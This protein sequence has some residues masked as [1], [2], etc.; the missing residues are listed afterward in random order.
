MPCLQ[1]GFFAM[2]VCA[3]GGLLYINLGYLGFSNCKHIHSSRF[4]ST[5]S[6]LLTWFSNNTKLHDFLN[7]TIYFCTLICP[8]RT[9][10]LL[11]LHGFLLTGLF[12]QSLKK[13]GKQRTPFCFQDLLHTVQFIK[14]FFLALLMIKDSKQ[15]I[16][17]RVNNKLKPF[18]CRYL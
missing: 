10:S 18:L 16:T 1:K 11:R 9:K 8:F 3:T 7:N 4:I 15:S 5:G 2:S 12:F 14:L 6:P 17:A 13:Q